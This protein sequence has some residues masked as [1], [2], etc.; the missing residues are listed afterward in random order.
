MVPPLTD[1]GAL[2]KWWSTLY[3][4]HANLSNGITFLHLAGLIVGGTIHFHMDPGQSGLAQGNHTY[5]DILLL[6]INY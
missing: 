3:S 6:T 5:S 2:I 1:P 4:D